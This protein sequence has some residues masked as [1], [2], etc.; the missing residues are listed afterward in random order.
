MVFE[1]PNVLNKTEEEITE[2]NSSNEDNNVF[3]SK[4]WK[5][6]IIMEKREQ[7]QN[8]PEILSQNLSPFI[9]QIYL[10]TNKSRC[11]A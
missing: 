5:E 3:T 8:D 6:K 4:G 9:F 10:W 2:N 1:V 11:P 7:T